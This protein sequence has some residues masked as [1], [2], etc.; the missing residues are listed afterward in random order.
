MSAH[1][2]PLPNPSA[3]V[4]PA[5]DVAHARLSHCHP[6]NCCIQLDVSLN[7][8]GPARLTS[9]CTALPDKF[10]TQVYSVKFCAG[11]LCLPWN[12]REFPARQSRLVVHCDDLN[13]WIGHPSSLPP[14]PTSPLLIG[15]AL[16]AVLIEAVRSIPNSRRSLCLI[17]CGEVER[18][19]IT[20]HGLFLAQARDCPCVSRASL[21]HP[22]FST[23]Q[24][25]IS[26]TTAPLAWAPS[27]VICGPARGSGRARIRI[28]TLRHAELHCSE[29]YKGPPFAWWNVHRSWIRSARAI[30]ERKHRGSAR[31]EAR[32]MDTEDS[33]PPGYPLFERGTNCPRHG[34]RRS[35]A[36]QEFVECVLVQCVARRLKKERTLP[37]FSSATTMRLPAE[38]S[39]TRI[40]LA[41]SCAGSRCLLI[42]SSLKTGWSFRSLCLFAGGRDPIVV[43]RQ[44]TLLEHARL[45]T[46]RP[47]ALSRRGF[48]ESVAQYDVGR[49]NQ[50]FAFLFW[51]PAQRYFCSSL[52]ADPR[53]RDTSTALSCLLAATF[54]VSPASPSRFSATSGALQRQYRVSV[55]KLYLANVFSFKQRA[56]TGQFWGIAALRD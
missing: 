26:G 46:R 31:F 56:V 34:V 49:N 37:A 14:S 7:S 1:C 4:H 21:L 32:T 5:R 55:H 6:A 2:F 20:E 40:S 45:G 8:S 53:V 29:I 28:S 27:G 33:V 22:P 43:A 50:T 47:V 16:H 41:S 39:G 44:P 24:S 10:L 51:S 38:F 48:Q 17:P 15:D 23:A 9:S 52:E 3:S 30:Y 54:S 13:R 25:T 19:T 11:V 42:E 12:P 35:F 18:E 36:E